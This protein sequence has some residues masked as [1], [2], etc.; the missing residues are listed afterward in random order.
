MNLLSVGVE[1]QLLYLMHIGSLQE[2]LQVLP[3]GEISLLFSPAEGQAE[4]CLGSGCE[5][6]VLKP[7]WSCLLM[8]PF[9][10]GRNLTF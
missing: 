6:Q 5:Y 9:S 7:K 3:Y 1:R 4:E 8:V 10:R 2:W